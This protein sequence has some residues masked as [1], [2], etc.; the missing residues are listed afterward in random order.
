MFDLPYTEICDIPILVGVFLPFSLQGSLM[1]KYPPYVNAYNSIPKLFDEIRSASV[2]AKITNDYI[3][4]VFGLKST[5]HRALIPLLKHLGFLDQANVPTQVYKDYRDDE[6]M[7]RVMAER[8][9]NAYSVL[10]QANEYAHK[11]SK[12]ELQSKLVNLAGVAKED[13]I[14]PAVVST[15]IELCKLADFDEAPITVEQKKV[16]EVKPDNSPKNT[17]S[18]NHS[19]GLSYTINLNLPAT[20]DIEVFNAI[21]KSLK[22]NLL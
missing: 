2:A 9:K 17:D 12:E 13:K 4:S 1:S 11:L 21:F 19:L 20:T 5:S 7:K 22:E 3:Y 18:L 14:V 16:V 10:Y 6:K 15:F 8:I